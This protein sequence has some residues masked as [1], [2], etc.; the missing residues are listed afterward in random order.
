L[1]ISELGFEGVDALRIALRKAAAKETMGSFVGFSRTGIL[2]AEYPE[3]NEDWEAY[4]MNSG[5]G[6]DYSVFDYELDW[7]GAVLTWA[8]Q[9][10]WERRDEGRT[11]SDEPILQVVGQFNDALSFTWKQYGNFTQI[12]NGRLGVG[13]AN[14][15]RFDNTVYSFFYDSIFVDPQACPTP[16][17]ILNAFVDAFFRKFTLSGYIHEQQP[18]YAICDQPG[19][20]NAIGK[21]FLAYIYVKD[22]RY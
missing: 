19:Y 16:D 4:L 6:A 13:Y 11:G 20:L 5:N 18:H 7:W 12:L 3:N 15:E 10:A 8:R 9:V 17:D 1:G 21:D 14:L 22:Q 2:S